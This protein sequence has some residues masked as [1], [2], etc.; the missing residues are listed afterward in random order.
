MV[1]LLA[2][3]RG[4]YVGWWCIAQEAQTPGYICW[5]EVK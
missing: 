5:E 3:D 4:G 2:G 1:R